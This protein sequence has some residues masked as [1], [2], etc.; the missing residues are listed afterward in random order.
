MWQ[1]LSSFWSNFVYV[2]TDTFPLTTE[3]LERNPISSRNSTIVAHLN[4]YLTD[5]RYV[6]I[7]IESD[8]GHHRPPTPKWFTYSF[9]VPSV[10]L[11]EVVP[12]CWVSG[13]CPLCWVSGGCPLCWVSGGCPLCWVS[14]SCP[15]C[16]V[17]GGCPL[18]WVS[19]SC[20]LCWVSGGCPPVLG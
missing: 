1:R 7:I 6:A 11:V 15:L 3:V 2:C 8:I 14:G 4:T 10:V 17:S 5:K 16:W 19:G 20:P 12:L 18:C 9:Q 13:G